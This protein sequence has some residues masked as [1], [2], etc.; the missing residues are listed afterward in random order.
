MK[1]LIKSGNIKV[2]AEFNISITPSDADADKVLVLLPGSK[3][4]AVDSETGAEINKTGQAKTTR[5]EDDDIA[6]TDGRVVK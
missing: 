4:R 3:I 1:V 2:E 6:Q 5:L